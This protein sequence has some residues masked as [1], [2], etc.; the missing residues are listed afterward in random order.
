MDDMIET[1]ADCIDAARYAHP[2]HPRER[3]RPF[4]EAEN[5]D[6]EYATRLAKA[7][8]KAMQE[9][10]PVRVWLRNHGQDSAHYGELVKI[11]DYPHGAITSGK[12]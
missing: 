8:L 12:Q 9:P 5:G 6:R 2:E 4:S 11:E 3:P 10:R 7:A 1:I